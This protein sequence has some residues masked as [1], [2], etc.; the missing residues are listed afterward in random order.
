MPFAAHALQ[1]VALCDSILEL[2]M[3]RT[4]LA[5]GVAVLASLLFVPHGGMH[6][7]VIFNRGRGAFWN[8]PYDRI[9]VTPLILQTVFAVIVATII[10]NLFPRRPRK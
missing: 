1:L 6:H 5:V 3:K 7:G 2:G 4:L 10:V 9:A 8:I